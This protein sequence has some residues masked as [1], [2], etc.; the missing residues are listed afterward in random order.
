MIF[1]R[2]SVL[3][4][5]IISPNAVQDDGIFFNNT[6]GKFEAVSIPAVAIT[7]TYV[8]GSEIEQLALVVQKGDT[9]IRTDINKTYINSTGNNLA[10]TDWAE[11][12]SSGV[13]EMVKASA[14]DT[15]A[16]YL[17]SKIDTTK[18]IMNGDTISVKDY[19]IYPITERLITLP[20]PSIYIDGSIV[21]RDGYGLYQKFTTITDD[22]AWDFISTIHHSQLVDI[23]T[24]DHHPKTHDHSV[25]SGSGAINTDQEA[26]FGD[27]AGG[28]YLNVSTDGTPSLFGTARYKHLINNTAYNM[29]P[30]GSTYN[31]ITTSTAGATTLDSKWYCRS[32]DDGIPESCLVTFELPANYEAGTDIDVHVH[33]TASSTVGGMAYGVGLLCVGDGGVLN[34]T[35]TYVTGSVTA[36]AVAYELSTINATFV[37]T[38]FVAGNSVSVILYRNPSDVAD[39]MFGDA[40]VISASV[41]VTANKLG[42]DVV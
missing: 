7:D 37:G 40:L 34:G 15:T 19:T 20:D 4:K 17:D 25:A 12:L 32:F 16:G 1:T 2:S 38:G 31:G 30:Y 22:P 33:W 11:V 18:M 42:G 6:T 39:T 35:E 28:N 23:N 8:V 24:D 13:D 21:A 36:P 41:E 27:V 29:Y 5:N 26:H 10:M 9:A 14:T 3:A